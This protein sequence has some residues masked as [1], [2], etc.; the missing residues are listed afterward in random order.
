M[1]GKRVMIIDDRAASRTYLARI[2]QREKLAAEIF[3]DGRS[4][5]RVLREDSTGIILVITRLRLPDSSALDL[6]QG[7]ASELPA[8]VPFIV[9]AER[10]TRQEII[11]A[12]RQGAYDFFEEPLDP[13]KISSA[14][15]RARRE[16]ENRDKLLRVYRGLREKKVHFE[17]GNDLNLVQPLVQAAVNEI[18]ACG[19][20]SSHHLAG[21]RMGLHELLVN[22]I[23]HGNL[24]ISSNLK[25]RADYLQYLQRRAR[26]APYRERRV[27]FEI[28]IIPTGFSCRIRDQGPGFDW[29]NLPHPGT[30]ENLGK[31]H[32]RGITMAGSFFDEFIFNDT[33]NEVT[34]KKFWDAA[35]LEPAT[36]PVN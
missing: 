13:R 8:P 16:A 29:R 17:I 36:E 34:V 7:L 18:S 19:R 35:P 15:A 32:G 9:I 21:L 5:G 25:E 4:A 12:F 20:V 27:T 6:M 22:A 28:H 30:P 26:S 24:E 3:S 33:G 10:G 14:L 2:I 23:E 1:T 11:Q 31:A